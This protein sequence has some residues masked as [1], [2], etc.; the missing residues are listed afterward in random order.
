LT[1]SDISEKLAKD[2]G[3]RL[4]V[5][6]MRQDACSLAIPDESFHL[7]ISSECI[8][9]TPKPNYALREMARIVKPGGFIIITSPNKLW[10]PVLW[11]SMISKIRN[12]S[13]NENWL[14]PWKAASILSDGGITDIRIRGCH[15][16]PWQ[17]PFAKHVLPVFD[18]FD[19]L[20]YPV[21]I[22]YGVG[23]KKMK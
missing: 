20:L 3:K 22:N 17:I 11:L 6:W 7:V 2:V 8:E 10:Y 15:L 18:R 21:M 14:F 5:N 13:G 1:V 4:R 23:G 12:F 16:F 9:H 19:R